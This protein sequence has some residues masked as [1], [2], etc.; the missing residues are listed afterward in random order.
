MFVNQS[1]TDMV[2]ALLQGYYQYI[3]YAL[4]LAI[5]GPVF[6]PK[7]KQRYI[8]G[9]PII[10]SEEPGGIRQARENFSTDARSILTE[11]Y[12]KAYPPSTSIPRVPVANKDQYK[13]QSPFYV[14]TRLGERLM[15]PTRYV[16]ELKNAPVKDV[17]FVATFFEVGI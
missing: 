2:V 4:L 17:D 14:P 9:V 1:R 15:I 16:E 3:L 13:C 6:Y 8:Q 12:E 11:G 5:G 10:G 7:N